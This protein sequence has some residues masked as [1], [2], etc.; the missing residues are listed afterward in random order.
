MSIHAH[1]PFC[2]DGN[3]WT[4]TNYADADTFGTLVIVAKD[5]DTAVKR[6]EK[7]LAEGTAFRKVTSAE[8]SGW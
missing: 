4:F 5:E 8:H 2:R 7:R 1:Y 3:R 6:L